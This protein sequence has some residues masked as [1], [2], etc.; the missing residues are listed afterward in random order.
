MKATKINTKENIFGNQQQNSRPE[1]DESS[2]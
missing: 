1:L 2:H